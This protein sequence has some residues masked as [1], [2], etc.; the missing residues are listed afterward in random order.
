[1]NS[2][3][4]ILLIILM[5]LVYISIFHQSL[6]VGGCYEVNKKQRIGEIGARSRWPTEP[7]CIVGG[8]GEDDTQRDTVCSGEFAN[9]GMYAEKEDGTPLVRIT[10][11]K[12]YYSEN[13][14]ADVKTCATLHERIHVGQDKTPGYFRLN[15]EVNAQAYIAELDCLGEAQKKEDDNNDGG[16]ESF[17]VSSSTYPNTIYYSQTPDVAILRNGKS[18]GFS[19]LIGSFKR[20]NIF[21]DISFDPIKLKTYTSIL[22][23]PES[24]IF[25]LENSDT[26][27]ATL[28]EYVTSGGVIICLSQQHGYEWSALPVPEGEDKV[29]GYGYREDMSCQIKGIEIQDWHQVL[30]GQLQAILDVNT[31]GYLTSWPESAKILFRRTK[32]GQPAG[33]MYKVG[34]GYVFVLC[35]YEDYAYTIN[36]STKSGR[37]LIRDI[38]TYAK[39]ITSNPDANDILPEYRPGASVIIPITIINKTDKE[40]V[41]ASVSVLTPDREVKEVRSQKSEFRRQNRKV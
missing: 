3:K 6:L 21:T 29:S 26:F 27:K 14:D 36:Q 10:Y 30:S 7:R 32:N 41:S 22:L 1:M 4:K 23:I 37:A 18:T 38:L 28:K 11:L 35:T 20:S 25:G 5:N 12:R 34:A 16:D 19:A 2:A 17:S 39:Y 15:C 33:I 9:T 40:S 13:Q 31:D 8:A 24:G